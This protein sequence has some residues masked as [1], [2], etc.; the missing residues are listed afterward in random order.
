MQS[1]GFLNVNGKLCTRIYMNKMI[2]NHV[3]CGVSVSGKIL[4]CRQLL[5]DF[6]FITEKIAICLL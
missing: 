4:F 5:V 3:L 1:F 6:S 2:A